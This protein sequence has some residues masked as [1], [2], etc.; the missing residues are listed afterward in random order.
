MGLDRIA[1]TLQALSAAGIPADRGYP[2]S[3]VP[4]LTEAVAAVNIGQLTAEETILRVTVFCPAELG[5]ALCEDTAQTVAQLL[6]QQGAVCT[7]RN[8][9]FS[10]KTGLF[11]AEVQV[12]W[13]TPVSCQVTVDN[14]AVSFL[15]GVSTKRT[16]EVNQVWSEEA[17]KFVIGEADLGWEITVEELLP[18]DQMLAAENERTFTLKIIR[19]GCA[20]TYTKCKWG[21]VQIEE[22]PFGLRK[23]RVARTW[24]DREVASE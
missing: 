2:T 20:E 21:K 24:E 5:G 6:A 3:K 9:G 7:V 8:C 4:Q 13:A 23:V 15:T 10:G 17:G 11:S 22:T 14:I 18:L 16:V 1:Q 12:Q 19:Q